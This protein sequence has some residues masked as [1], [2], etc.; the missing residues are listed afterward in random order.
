M[1][2]QTT[3]DFIDG[4]SKA[5]KDAY[6]FWR[7]QVPY[8]ECSGRLSIKLSSDVLSELDEISNEISQ[9]RKKAKKS[10]TI[11]YTCFDSK[12][13]L[14]LQVTELSTKSGDLVVTHR[15]CDAHEETASGRVEVA[16]GVNDWI[17]NHHE[18]LGDYLQLLVPCYF[19]ALTRDGVP[20]GSLERLCSDS[21]IV[22]SQGSQGVR[23]FVSLNQPS[24][25]RSMS[26]HLDDKRIPQ[27]HA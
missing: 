17:T 9:T 24:G 21:R 1:A 27:Y 2:S 15:K 7:M 20:Q 11:D 6:S 22:R 3:T 26:I 8:K 5:Y 19:V 18:H 16:D 23:A 4:A 12:P 14:G 13:K 10:Q 25:H